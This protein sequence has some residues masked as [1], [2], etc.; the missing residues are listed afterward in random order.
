MYRLDRPNRR[1]QRLAS[2]SLAEQR[3]GERKDLQEWIANEPS[4]L[5]EDLLI[6]QKEFDGFDSTRERLDLLALDKDANLVVIENKLD[7]SGRDVIWQALKYASYCSRLTRENIREMY[8]DYL[9][10]QGS[11]GSAA[12]LL[13]DF[14]NAESLED[15]EV[16]KGVSQRIILVARSFRR[17]VTSTVMWL[18]NYGMVI[19]CIKVTPYILEDELILGFEQIIPGRDTEEFMIGIAD[20]SR[21]ELSDRLRGGRGLDLAF[22]FW[23][24]AV[25]VLHNANLYP[26]NRPARTMA[27]ATASGLGGVSFTLVIGL[28]AS[29][30]EVYISRSDKKENKA[31]FDLLYAKRKEIEQAFGGPLQWSRLDNRTASRIRYDLDKGLD[32]ERAWN[33]ITAFFVDSM[34]RL[35]AAVSPHLEA[36]AQAIESGA[37]AAQTSAPR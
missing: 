15:V 21:E 25:P 3:L 1:L 8:Q 4:V 6:I 36:A 34:S 33:E 12:D 32:D 26:D 9:Q 14:L 30:S 19:Q 18:L 16:N 29:R 35:R 23:Q 13:A 28:T 22:R 2:T 10:S 7:D 31:I 37:V 20:K 24:I 5:G 11:T 27:L 17:E